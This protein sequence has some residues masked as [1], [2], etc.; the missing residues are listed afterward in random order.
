MFTFGFVSSVTRDD[1]FRDSYKVWTERKEGL[2]KIVRDPQCPDKSVEQMTGWFHRLYGD[3][4]V[5][6]RELLERE[7]AILRQICPLNLKKRNESLVE[8][9]RVNADRMAD[10]LS[11]KNP[12]FTK[13]PGELMLRRFFDMFAMQR[14]GYTGCEEE[15]TRLSFQIAKEFADGV[16]EQMGLVRY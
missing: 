4:S 8:Q 5:C 14:L 16:V 15:Q 2:Q 3:S 1:V 11:Q 13:G 10:F 7:N 6:F 9:G 12:W